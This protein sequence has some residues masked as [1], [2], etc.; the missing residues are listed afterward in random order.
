MFGLCTLVELSLLVLTAPMPNQTSRNKEIRWATDAVGAEVILDPWL[1]MLA[2]TL[3]SPGEIKSWRHFV[4]LFQYSQLTFF[5]QA[6][7]T[8]LQPDLFMLNITLKK[9][10]RSDCATG[11]TNLCL[12]SWTNAC[13]TVSSVATHKCNSL[14]IN[15]TRIRI[16]LLHS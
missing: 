3:F 9:F 16:Q 1:D 12:L 10:L 11:D 14:S 8:G 2:P 15:C 13:N 7:K 6:T 5:S 4:D